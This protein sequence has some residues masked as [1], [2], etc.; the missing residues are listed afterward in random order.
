[1]TEKAKTYEVPIYMVG[2]KKAARNI[3][4]AIKK[5]AKD[6]AM[7]DLGDEKLAEMAWPELVISAKD[8]IDL[9]NQRYDLDERGY[10]PG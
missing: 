2:E 3:I 7:K 4:N 10:E 6:T 1:M 8:I 9:I 5:A